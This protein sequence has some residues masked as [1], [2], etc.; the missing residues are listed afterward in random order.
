VYLLHFDRLYI[1]RMHHYVSFTHDLQRG[2]ENHRQGTAGATT[3]LAF[4]QGI[5]FTLARAWP[6]TPKLNRQINDRGPVN[7]CP[8]R[9]G[10]ELLAVSRHGPAESVGL[11]GGKGYPLA[12]YGGILLNR[13]GG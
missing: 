6:G 7:Y 1:G 4:D 5:G 8:K 9:Y 10:G 13:T 11:H 12:D 2:L 3:K